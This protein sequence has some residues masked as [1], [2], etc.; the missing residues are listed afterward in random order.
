MKYTL[1][2]ILILA[3]LAHSDVIRL[4]GSKEGKCTFLKPEQLKDPKVTSIDIRFSQGKAKVKKKQIRYVI[5]NSDT[6]HFSK[7]VYFQEIEDTTNTIYNTPKN[8]WKKGVYRSFAEFYYN[9][10]TRS[11]KSLTIDDAILKESFKGP[12]FS[13]YIYRKEMLKDWN[14]IIHG[15]VW[16]YY[17]GK[18]LLYNEGRYLTPLYFDENKLWSHNILDKSVS[19][20]SMGIGAIGPVS[21]GVSVR[22]EKLEETISFINKESGKVTYLD[23]KSF[24]KMISPYQNLASKFKELSLK[25]KKKQLVHF[26]YKYREFI[27]NEG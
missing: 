15:P 8:E 18:K 27:K 3:I 20:P 10:P 9:K 11:L 6:L 14:P 17:D 25:Q 23:K 22:N 12:F 4:N 5:T 19:T 2:V 1:I 16:G 26:Y 21:I 7:G 13:F 24:K